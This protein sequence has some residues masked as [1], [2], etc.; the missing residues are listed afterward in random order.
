MEE[1]IEDKSDIDVPG[2]DDE[3][4]L[5]KPSSSVPPSAKLQAAEY[6]KYHT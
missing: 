1:N 3:D 2:P 5:S 6:T 4:D